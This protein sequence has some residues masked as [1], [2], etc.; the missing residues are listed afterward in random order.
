[1][2]IVLTWLRLEA[3]RRW[4]SLVVLALLVAVGT[5]PV[6]TASAGAR[7]GQ[8]A[9]DRLWAQTLPATVTVL[10][11]QPGFDWSK[12]RVLP[13]VAALSEFAVVSNYELSCC[14]A[15]QTGF[16]AVDAVYGTA[17]ERPAM[18]QG[19]LYRADR[20]DEIV[21]TPQFMSVYHK[22]L[23]DSVTLLLATPQQANE[24]LDTS[25]TQP[26]G[27]RIQARIVGV[28]RNVFGSTT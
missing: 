5:G 9:F 6:L 14:Q 17:L 21:A 28:A 4:V 18:L 10:P 7:R 16:P 23:G 26:S 2:R 20:A 12:I 11:N 27:P 15:A 19:R 24:G 1:M 8:S 3:R 13:E 22:H 25:T